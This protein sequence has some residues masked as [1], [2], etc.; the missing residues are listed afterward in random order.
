MFLL[1]GR[2]KEENWRGEGAC[3]VLSPTPL[4]PLP[5]LP[6][7][8]VIERRR[9]VFSV[10]SLRQMPKKKS[11]DL[12]HQK[13]IFHGSGSRG[14]KKKFLFYYTLYGT[15]PAEEAPPPPLPNY[16]LYDRTLLV[17]HVILSLSLSNGRF[18]EYLYIRIGSISTEYAGL[19]SSL[20]SLISSILHALSQKSPNSLTSRVP[21]GPSCASPRSGG[22][23]KRAINFASLLGS[24]VRTFKPPYVSPLPPRPG[25]ATISG[26]KRG[27]LLTVQMLHPARIFPP[28]YL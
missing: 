16:L 3:T 26:T 14:E 4:P 27:P 18:A 24:Y 13:T 7:I 15:L 22:G 5:P 20:F 2:K 19:A 23:T 6:T 25:P 17:L 11:K 21:H 28:R 12:F 8:P 10:R 9:D 1:R